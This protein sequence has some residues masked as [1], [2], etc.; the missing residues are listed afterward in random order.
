MNRELFLAIFNACKDNDIKINRPYRLP[1]G[2]SVGDPADF[3]LYIIKEYNA[4]KYTVNNSNVVLTKTN[5]IEEFVEILIEKSK[6]KD[7]QFVQMVMPQLAVEFA[8]MTDTQRILIRHII[9]YQSMS[10]ILIERWDILIKL[11]DKVVS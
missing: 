8:E 7:L 2:G 3:Q 4:E 5:A 6:G 9:D 11:N 10:D 1:D